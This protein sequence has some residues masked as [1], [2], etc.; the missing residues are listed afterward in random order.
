MQE[1]AQATLN[2]RGAPPR[3]TRHQRLAGNQL[4]LLKASIAAATAS[5]SQ[6]GSG[7]L[8][9]SQTNRMLP[10]NFKRSR[11]PSGH[12]LPVIKRGGGSTRSSS[13]DLY[14]S[15][16]EIPLKSNVQNSHPGSGDSGN[17]M[18]SR[19]NRNLL[20]SVSSE[21]LARR[22]TSANSIPVTYKRQQN[23]EPKQ[24]RQAQAQGKATTSSSE[25]LPSHNRLNRF[26]SKTE[27]NEYQ[28]VRDLHPLFRTA[29]ST[30]ISSLRF[31]IDFLT[32]AWLLNDPS[33]ARN[34]MI[35]SRRKWR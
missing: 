11:N 35:T 19:R 29:W 23:E 9:S 7:Y 15:S 13:Q 28:Q 5:T 34:G 31:C 3:D 1:N 22:V 16:T 10:S 32:F 30:Q 26:T 33:C 12:E 21:K 8:P 27:V 4:N 2:S 24:E 20:P 18:Q 17:R 14:D 25:S 6:G